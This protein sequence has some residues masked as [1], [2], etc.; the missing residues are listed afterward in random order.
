[1]PVF[2]VEKE[3][4]IQAKLAMMDITKNGQTTARTGARFVLSWRFI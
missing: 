3:G 1:V 4:R 2:F